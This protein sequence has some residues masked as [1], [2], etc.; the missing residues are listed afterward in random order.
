MSP[1]CHAHVVTC[2]NGI[3]IWITTMDHDNDCDC[4]KHCDSDCDCVPGSVAVSL[5]NYRSDYS[6]RYFKAHP[7][8][9]FAFEEDCAA[10]VA[11]PMLGNCSEELSGPL[12]PH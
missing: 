5:F 6:F 4:N 11:G 2:S 12:V 8:A 10:L 1:S 9:G 3:G 7:M